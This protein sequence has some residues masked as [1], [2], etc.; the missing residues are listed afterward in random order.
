MQRLPTRKQATEA[1]LDSASLHDAFGALMIGKPYLWHA[2]N[3]QCIIDCTYLLLFNNVR[4]VPGPKHSGARPVPGHESD[5]AMD[6]PALLNPPATRKAEASLR[7]WLSHSGRPLEVAWRQTL[8]KPELEHWCSLQRQ[9]FWEQHI[10]VNP[11][12]FNPEFIPKIAA[13]LDISIREIQ[14]VH[15]QSTN[16]IVV[17]DWAKGRGGSVADLADHAFILSC[18]IRGK[19][20]EFMARESDLQLAAH[21]HRAVIASRT[22]LGIKG[23]NFP[24]TNSA[25]Y[26]VRLLVGSALVERDALRVQTWRTNVLKAREALS[27]GTIALPNLPED[28][29]EAVVFMAARRLGIEVSSERQRRLLSFLLE[30]NIAVYSGLVLWPWGTLAAAGARLYKLARG[31]SLADEVVAAMRTTREFHRLASA[32]PG[33]IDRYLVQG[34]PARTSTEPTAAA[35]QGHPPGRAKDARG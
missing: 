13:V 22:A 4:I 27:R 14:G 16:P 26:F 28:Q 24:A 20:H 7:R 3:H 8:A 25:L 30:T 15:F 2:W 23:V 9:L 35:E 19:F 10:R 31:K 18:L 6:L 12:L 34:R 1:F 11:G 33:R 32:I 21:P 17:K 29:A 5:L